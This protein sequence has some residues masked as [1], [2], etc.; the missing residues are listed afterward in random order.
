MVGK[1]ILNYRI[2]RLIGSG[3]MGA[4]Y[5]ASNLNMDQKVAIKVLN[6]RLSQN[7]MLRER[8]KKEA[9]LLSSLDHPNIVRFLNFVENK[10]GVFLIM[11]YVEGVTLDEYIR[12]TT[13][14]LVE[15]RAYELFTPILNA[16]AYAH[17]RGVVHRD[18]KPANIILTKDKDVKIL[19]FGI[20]S[21]VNEASPE[22]EGMVMGTPIYMSPEQ[23]RGECPESTSDIYSLG[24][25]LFQMLT[26][27]PPYNEITTSELRLNTLIQQEPLPRM[28]EFYPFVSDKLQRVVDRATQKEAGKRYASCH[29]FEQALTAAVHPARTSKIVLYGAATLLL[30]LLVGGY[31]LWSSSRV[32][33]V[34]YKDYVEQWGVPVGIGKLTTDQVAHR[35]NSYRMEYKRRQLI[36]VCLVN[37][38]GILKE[39]V[40]T[41]TYNRA[42][43]RLFYYNNRG[44]V[45][46]V[47]NKNSYGK[48]LYLQDYNDKLNEITFRNNDEF[49][50]E[51]MLNANTLEAFT[52]PF[53]NSETSPKGKISRHRVTYNDAGYVTQLSYYGWHNE[54]VCDID[55][56]YARRFVVAAN[57]QIV[58][59][60]YLGAHGQ[61]VANGEHIGIKKFQYDS[62]NQRISSAYFTPDGK[63]WPNSLNV[64]VA[65]ETHDKYGNVVEE[66]YYGP[67]GEPIKRS[68]ISISFFKI[69]F[70]DGGF[71]TRETY[72]NDLNKPQ[73]GGD[74]LFE[75]VAIGYDSNH[76][77]NRLTYVTKEN[78]PCVGFPG[79][80]PI[81]EF[82]NDSK[83]N[84]LEMW[85]RDTEGNLLAINGI[86][87]FQMQYDTV[88]NCIQ[89]V[90]YGTDTKP[91]LQA[92]GCAGYKA[93]FNALNQ[94]IRLTTLGV[95]LLPCPDT[96]GV[97]TTLK[98]YDNRGNLSS[99]RF[100][101]AQ[102]QRIFS[103]EGISRIDYDYDDL[104]N[105]QSRRLYDTQDVL[106][107]DTPTE[108]ESSEDNPPATAETDSP[109]S[110]QEEAVPQVDYMVGM[111]ALAKKCPVDLNRNL[112]ETSIKVHS[113]TACT[114]TIR[115]KNVSKYNC[116]DEELDE[117]KRW[118][119]AF[120]KSIRKEMDLP[121]KVKITVVMNDKAQREL[122][123]V[124]Q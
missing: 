117:H 114:I 78:K 81:L 124:N 36:R 69:S 99:I 123:R 10:E 16:F 121:T 38:A 26:G 111:R 27:S 8:L 15:E 77:I 86:A 63:P 48:T 28:K 47:V 110:V 34:Y 11:E 113:L 45:E 93:Q 95:D 53:D 44:A 66:S 115:L 76:Y 42:A 82:V 30:G 107:G 61:P 119:G 17:K 89:R 23:T 65:K 40:D 29:D 56:I 24:V 122:F 72:F 9:T 105:V 2:E 31:F 70:D 55:S 54:P 50:S 18:I 92:N 84:S 21:I 52:N 88:G 41:E 49:R 14:P 7:R 57:G 100:L 91:C 98:Q 25:L 79:I 43:E 64:A 19:D 62:Q 97:T 108:E 1:Q 83:G 73:L 6:E 120:I 102:D 32:K 22:E 68:D 103:T 104:G 118:A 74:S 51:L 37:S 67:D 94:V 75:A 101:G 33:T 3:G 39:H 90:T 71:R 106:L 109:V 46:T 116:T 35:E 59:E 96:L 80:P 5:L 112:E 87:G 4:V 58:E 13:G 60:H 20:A 12:K 85:R